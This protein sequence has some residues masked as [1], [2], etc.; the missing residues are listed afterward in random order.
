MQSANSP[1]IV[2]SPSISMV[3]S[4]L[5]GD[6]EKITSGVSSLS[7]TGN[8][9]QHHNI[10]SSALAQSL[11]IG[12]PGI[13]ASPLLAEF[14]SPDGTHGVASTIVSGNSNVVEQPL[15]RLLKVV[16]GVYFI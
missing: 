11:A 2:P 16:S 15:D 1:F 8:N 13:S 7:N 5:P 4:P 6:S 9:V 3:P 14:T 12:T 10:G